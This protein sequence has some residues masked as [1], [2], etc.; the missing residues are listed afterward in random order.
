MEEAPYNDIQFRKLEKEGPWPDN[1]EAVL[2]MPR[3][4]CRSFE[5]G[6]QNTKVVVDV[7]R[8]VMAYLVYT[9]DGFGDR[10]PLHWNV[11]GVKHRTDGERKIDSPATDRSSRGKTDPELSPIKYGWTAAVTFELH[12]VAGWARIRERR[13][14]ETETL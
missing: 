2:I 3:D 12:E 13:P 10:R 1:T 4:A 6:H 14:I 8:A 11:L 7:P 9:T 5:T